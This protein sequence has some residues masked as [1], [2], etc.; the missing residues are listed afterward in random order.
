MGLKVQVGS[1]KLSIAFLQEDPPCHGGRPS[2]SCRA[3][4]GSGGCVH[5]LRVSATCG[6]IGMQS[7]LRTVASIIDVPNS[8]WL[9]KG[10]CL[11]LD[12]LDTA[13]K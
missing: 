9:N 12:S 6:E 5:A 2:L 1:I 8:H 4:G 7:H 10:G 11:A 13:G 3:A